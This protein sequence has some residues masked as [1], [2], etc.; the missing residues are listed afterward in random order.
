MNFANGDKYEGDFQKD[1]ITG[2]GTYSGNDGSL[3]TGDFKEGKK[4][5]HG[6]LLI[7]IYIGSQLYP[8]KDKYEGLWE[9]DKRHG[10]GAMV[11]ASGEKCESEFLN[12]QLVGQG[13]YMQ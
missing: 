10:K 9:N 12:D 7:K 6:I 11:W 3:Y 5:G 2:K 1:N 13:I 8:N 4:H